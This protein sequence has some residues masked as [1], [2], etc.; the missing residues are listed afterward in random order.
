MHTMLHIGA[1][2]TIQ[3]IRGNDSIILKTKLNYC[4][5]FGYMSDI[6]TMLINKP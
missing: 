2:Q 5:K 1:N 3:L 6:P 4:N